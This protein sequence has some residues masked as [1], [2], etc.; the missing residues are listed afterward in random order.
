M[1]ASSELLVHGQFLVTG[2]AW[3]QPARIWGVLLYKSKGEL[4]SCVCVCVC[5]GG[6]GVH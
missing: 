2:S 4:P 5:W 3:S 6:G 1:Y